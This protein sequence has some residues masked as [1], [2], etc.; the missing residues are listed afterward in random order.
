[1]CRFLPC[2]EEISRMES[3]GGVDVGTGSARSSWSE[4]RSGSMSIGR[5][6]YSTLVTVMPSS[7][8]S[9]SSPRSVRHFLSHKILSRVSMGDWRSER[10]LA[11][12]VRPLGMNTKPKLVKRRA[13]AGRPRQDES[14]RRVGG[15]REEGRTADA[16]EGERGRC[17][18]LASPLAPRLLFPRRPPV[19]SACLWSGR[20]RSA[21]GAALR[22]FSQTDFDSPLPPCM[23]RARD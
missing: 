9:S 5:E 22:V 14:S 11:Q 3:S 17:T 23:T 21:S 4:G 1:M 20:T 7:E 10:G 8:T 13:R 18:A 6:V 12:S 16:M 15:N 2:Q 19:G